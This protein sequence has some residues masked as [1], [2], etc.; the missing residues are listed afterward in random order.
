MV[1]HPG[2]ATLGN[3]I[4]DE[5][6]E[7][8]DPASTY[9]TLTPDLSGHLAFLSRKP[10]PKPAQ[11]ARQAAQ[12]LVDQEYGH[13]QSVCDT[14]AE[15][16]DD[17]PDE[18]PRSLAETLEK[19]EKGAFSKYQSMLAKQG[20]LDGKIQ[21][22][23]VERDAA[24]AELREEYSQCN[25]IGSLQ[26]HFDIR[27]EKIEYKFAQDVETSRN[28]LSDMQFRRQSYDG[29]SKTWSHAAGP[30]SG[31]RANTSTLSQ[32]VAGINDYDQTLDHMRTRGIQSGRRMSN[33]ETMEYS[34]SFQQTQARSQ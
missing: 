8:P 32:R 27:W 16:I 22:A 30:Y 26:A 17:Y 15:I 10:N 13:W 3:F 9:R 21:A 11:E 12:R 20:S 25:V 28:V 29:S 6:E 19:A 4:N 18:V 31:Q 33:P 23:E 5:W 1:I 7:T 24:I 2:D 14:N 34:R